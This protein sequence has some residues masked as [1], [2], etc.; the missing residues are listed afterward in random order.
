MEKAFALGYES[1]Y[2]SVYTCSRPAGEL[3][4]VL[5]LI[6]I[7][8]SCHRTQ[9]RHCIALEKK[10]LFKKE[11]K[12]H[13]LS[14]WMTFRLFSLW[15]RCTHTFHGHTYYIILWLSNMFSC[16][17]YIFHE[18]GRLADKHHAEPNKEANRKTRE[19]EI[20]ENSSA[21]F[22]CEESNSHSVSMWAG[23]HTET[24]RCFLHFLSFTSRLTPFLSNMLFTASAFCQTCTVY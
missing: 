16:I 1:Q 22:V 23:V 2:G 21:V 4:T 11:C 13:K 24:S 15:F 18:L 20:P 7:W 17:V 14:N 9:S 8:I 10:V 6:L 3:S 5:L 19:P 12:W